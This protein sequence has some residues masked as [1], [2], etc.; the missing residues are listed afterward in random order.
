MTT[1]RMNVSRANKLPFADPFDCLIAGADI[2]LNLPLITRD[3][4]IAES[5]LL[6][7]IWQ[8]AQ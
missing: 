7:T 2:R 1:R 6:Q 4:L 5:N 8:E 3:R